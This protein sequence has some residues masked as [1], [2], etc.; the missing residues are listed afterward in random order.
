MLLR[1]KRGQSTGVGRSTL[2]GRR[3]KQQ[4]IAVGM[5]AIMKDGNAIAET[6]GLK[7]LEDVAGSAIGSNHHFTQPSLLGD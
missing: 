3:L 1:Q 5:T 6:W 2:A 4:L 7:H